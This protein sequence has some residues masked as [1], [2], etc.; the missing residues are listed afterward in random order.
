MRKLVQLDDET[1]GWSEIDQV[2]LR[3]VAQ[4]FRSWLVS[5]D[6]AEDPFGF[7]KH[8]LPLVDAALSGEMRLPYKSSRPHT[9]E[10]GEGLLPREYTRISAPFYNTI[11]GAHLVP[12]QIIEKDGKKYA[13]L[14]FEDLPNSKVV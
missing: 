11:R 3:R 9:R 14:V 12:P 7:L 8:D 5:V 4:E 6:P 10:L 2:K 1:W 13:W